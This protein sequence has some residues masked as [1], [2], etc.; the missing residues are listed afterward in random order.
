MKALEV[1]AIN[2][3]KMYLPVDQIRMVGPLMDRGLS[4]LSRAVIYVDGLPP[5]PVKESRRELVARIG[6]EVT[7]VVANEGSD[8]S[9]S[10]DERP[11]V[12][13]EPGTVVGEERGA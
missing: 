3:E 8:G 6:W 7:D 1:I 5:L 4:M 11:A 10:A 2:N 13:E 9:D 12:G